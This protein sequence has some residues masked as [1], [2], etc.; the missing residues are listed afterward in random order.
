M[1]DPRIPHESLIANL[2]TY[3]EERN[4]IANESFLQKCIQLYDIIA[5]RHGVMVI[6]EANSGKTSVL[7]A[8][9]KSME[10]KVTY[11]TMNPKSIFIH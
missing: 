2:T 6:G 7:D 11:K 3:C 1:E 5:V 8:L 10:G 4:L 9:S